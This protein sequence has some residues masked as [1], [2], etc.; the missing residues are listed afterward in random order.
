M[1]RTGT[2]TAVRGEWLDIAFCRPSDCGKCNACLGGKSQTTLRVKGEA[3]VGDSAVVSMPRKS[4]LRATALAYLLPLIGL[5]AG[6]IGFSLLFPQMGDGGAGLGA[7]VGLGLALLIVWITEGHRRRDPA[8]Q[9]HLVR[10][11][12]GGDAADHADD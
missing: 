3:H 8:W 1:E 5:L 12:P 4:M 11:I 6:M 10:V 9:V 2:V 7:A